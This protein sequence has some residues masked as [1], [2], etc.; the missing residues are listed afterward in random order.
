M[1]FINIPREA[2]LDTNHEFGFFGAVLNIFHREQ[3]GG[4]IKCS[5][6]SNDPPEVGGSKKDLKDDSGF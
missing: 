2:I 4:M 1:D 6:R 3:S 5:P